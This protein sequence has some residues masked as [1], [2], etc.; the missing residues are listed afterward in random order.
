MC[1]VLQMNHDKAIKFVVFKV[2]LNETEKRL[3]EWMK[4]MLKF[5]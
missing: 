1:I 3:S 2:I 4:K 5:K